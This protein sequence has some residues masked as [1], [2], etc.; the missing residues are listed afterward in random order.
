VSKVAGE[1]QVSSWRFLLCLAF[2]LI[3]AVALI[4]RL[5]MLQLLDVEQGQQFLQSQGDARTVRYAQIPAHRGAILDRN[6]QPLAVSTPVLTLSL[7]PQQFDVS[8]LDT[9]ARLLKSSNTG[10]SSIKTAN[11]CMSKNT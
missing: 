4:G 7:N 6:G 2:L 5:A 10:F 8:N 9:L 11:S 1:V 3:L